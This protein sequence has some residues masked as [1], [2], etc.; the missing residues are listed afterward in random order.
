[1]NFL[2]VLLFIL[3]FYYLLR[4]FGRWFAPRLFQYAIKKTEE[5]FR[6]QFQ[7]NQEPSEAEMQVGDIHITK[8]KPGAH[9]ESKATVGEYID[10]EEID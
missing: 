10:Y 7:G 6:D 3:L 8:N 4:L 2:K 9:R 5:R 1:M